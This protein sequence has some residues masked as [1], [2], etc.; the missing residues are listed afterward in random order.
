MEE[1]ID[2][3]GSGMLHLIGALII[4]GM[5]ITSVKSGGVIYVMA[6]NFMRSIVG[7]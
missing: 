4:L 5:V 6:E 3:F 7:G 2:F 1:I